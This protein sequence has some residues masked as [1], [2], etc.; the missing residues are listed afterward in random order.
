MFCFF[1]QK[2]FS[3][4]VEIEII[5]C[6]QSKP[7]HGLFN[8]QTF[9]YNNYNYNSGECHAVYFLKLIFLLMPCT[10]KILDQF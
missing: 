5:F 2:I 8:D 10:Y 3:Y 9:C 6:E 4:A 1:I 7:L